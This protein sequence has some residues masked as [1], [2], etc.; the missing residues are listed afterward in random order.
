MSNLLPLKEKSAQWKKKR[1]HA[2]SSAKK[3]K[4]V[5]LFNDARLRTRRA[6]LP[7]TLYSDSAVLVLNKTLLDCDIALLALK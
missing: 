3:Q 6:L 4:D 7:Q 1:V 5:M 2:M